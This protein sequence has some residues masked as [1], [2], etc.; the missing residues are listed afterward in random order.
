MN[1]GVLIK[2][3]PTSSCLHDLW[4]LDGLNAQSLIAANVQDSSFSLSLPFALFPASSVLLDSSHGPQPRS[5]SGAITTR[6]LT[7]GSC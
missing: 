5:T 6:L 7:S 2:A 4:V 1:W 3:P